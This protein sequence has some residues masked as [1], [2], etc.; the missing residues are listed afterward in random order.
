MKASSGASRY[1]WM[2]WTNDDAQLPTPTMAT[3]IFPHY[4]FPP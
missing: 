4:V 3:L 1:L 2:P